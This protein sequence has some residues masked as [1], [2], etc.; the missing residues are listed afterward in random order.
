M[1]KIRL[2]LTFLLLVSFGEAQTFT[3]VTG[4][5]TTKAGAPVSGSFNIAWPAYDRAG[6][7]VDKGS[8]TMYISSGVLDVSIP[9]V[10]GSSP[11]V[12]YQVT[13]PG[14]VDF[15]YVPA[16]SVSIDLSQ[17]PG[18]A[19]GGGGGGGG[20]VYPGA[21]MSVSTGYAWGTSI[22]VS[23]APGANT[24]PETDGSG[25]LNVAAGFASSG[26]FKF[27]GATQAKPAAPA[28]GSQLGWFDATNLLLQGEDSSGTTIWSTVAPLA[29]PSDTLVVNYIDQHGV[30][31]RIA[32]SV[33]ATPMATPGTSFTVSVPHG[34]GVCTGTCTVT[35]AAPTAAGDDFCVWNDVGV[36]SA[37]TISG[38]SGVYFSNVAM[39]GYGAMSGTFTATA[40]AGNKVCMVARDTTHWHVLSTVG[41]WTAN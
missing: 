41:T 6:L 39:T 4:T 27:L 24:I 35:V 20:M 13:A 36:S 16:S 11:P 25:I 34:Y 40:A 7:H 22:P 21:G 19:G 14:L 33:P 30:Q 18:L 23:A 17:V 26:A 10:D 37:I 1:K 5:L 31:Q 29:N 12:V 28:S 3:R 8:M 9:P 15:W 32:Q 2:L 38:V